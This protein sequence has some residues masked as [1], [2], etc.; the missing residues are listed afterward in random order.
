MK[1]KQVKK[2]RL[3]RETLRDLEKG[4]LQKVVGMSTMTGGCTGTGEGSDGGNS[5]DEAC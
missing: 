5:C 3:S 1:K 4:D 2:L